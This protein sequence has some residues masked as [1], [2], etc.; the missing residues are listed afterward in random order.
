MAALNGRVKR[1]TF[2]A[3]A[4]L[5]RGEAVGR[6]EHIL[7]AKVYALVGRSGGRAG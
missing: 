4:V 5:P 6:H 3:L 1:L 2:P 7:D